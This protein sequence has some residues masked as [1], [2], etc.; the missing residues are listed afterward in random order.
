VL[1]LI[2]GA[3]HLALVAEINKLTQEAV[4]PSG[5]RLEFEMHGERFFQNLRLMMR[6]IYAKP[7]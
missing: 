7:L 2:V 4:N 5:R 1:Y 3:G 6:F